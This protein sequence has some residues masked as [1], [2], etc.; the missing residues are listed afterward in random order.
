MKSNPAKKF[1]E[2]QKFLPGEICR[3]IIEPLTLN[4]WQ[5]PNDPDDENEH[6]KQ[7]H[8]AIEFTLKDILWNDNDVL[9]A[10]SGRCS[11]KKVFLVADRAVRLTWSYID[12]TPL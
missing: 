1:G 7:L 11:A 12:W 8:I 10:A 9:K 2:T 4:V 5:N 3:V 6:F